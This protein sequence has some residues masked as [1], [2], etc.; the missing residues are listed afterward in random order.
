MSNP[1]DKL[2]DVGKVP[3][4]ANFEN[5]AAVPPMPTE[6]EVSM[7]MRVVSFVL[8]RSTWLLREPTV[9]SAD[10]DA[11]NCPVYVPFVHITEAMVEF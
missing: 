6:P 2:E 8:N 10:A 5:A 3:A 4:I 7:V 11:S 9:T 1:T